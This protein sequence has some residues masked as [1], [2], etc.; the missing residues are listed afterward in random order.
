M[1]DQAQQ[2]QEKLERYRHEVGAHR[3]TSMSNAEP[4]AGDVDPRRE[5]VECRDCGGP[6]EVTVLYRWLASEADPGAYAWRRGPVPPVVCDSCERDSE[7]VLNEAFGVAPHT[8]TDPTDWLRAMGVNTRKHGHATLDNFDATDAPKAIAQARVFVEET[9][10]SSKH[11]RVGGL[12]LVGR[13]TGTGKSHLAV[14]IMR[15]VREL[16]KDMRI[17]FE[18]ADRLVTRVQDS[19]GSGTTDSLIDERATADMYVLDD[20]GREKGTADALRVLCTILDER[21]GAPTV[22]TSNALPR[23]LGLRHDDADM[24]ARVASRL[25]DAVYKYVAVEGMDRR[26]RSA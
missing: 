8:P 22:I 14:A 17:V 23:E 15:A 3:P 5:D 13:Q 25:G 11:D 18:P 4:N 7:R 9:A 1:D 26:F 6:I 10:A 21:E 12:Y 2:L 20:L 19:Y 24:W 16:R